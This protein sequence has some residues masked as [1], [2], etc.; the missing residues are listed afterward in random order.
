[1]QTF[2]RAA[3]NVS[4]RAILYADSETGSMRQAIAE[5]RRRRER[6]VAY[7]LE[8]GITPETIRKSVSGPIGRACEADYVAVPAAEEWEFRSREEM[9]KLRNRLRKDMERAAK[10]LDFERAA[11]LRDR[12]LAL[13]KVELAA[14]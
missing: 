6:Q 2:G 8:R 10:K 4:G 14:G 5:T 7:N 1:V 13:E 3:R 9:L 11:E 12:L